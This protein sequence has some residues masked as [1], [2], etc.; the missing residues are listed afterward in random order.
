MDIKILSNRLVNRLNERNI[1]SLD[2]A[3]K[4]YLFFIIYFILY[5]RKNDVIYNI[6]NKKILVIDNFYICPIVW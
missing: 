4:Y 1:S 3:N 6:K 2:I 5:Q